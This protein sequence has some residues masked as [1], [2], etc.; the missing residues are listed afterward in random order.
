M[1]RP[2]PRLVINLP[3]AENVKIIIVI[4]TYNSEEFVNDLFASL[5][6][7]DYDLS[8]VLLVVV[9]NASKDNTL[10]KVLSRLSRVGNLNWMV[11]GLSRNYGF[12]YGNNIALHLARRVLGDLKDYTVLFL[13]PDTRILQNNFLTIVERLSSYFPL[14]GFAMLS[15]NND[16][17]DSLG[18]FVDYIGNPQDLLCGVPLTY[19]IER[20]LQSLPRIYSVTCACFAVFAVRGDVLERLG[21]LRGFYVIYFEDTEYCLRAWSMGIPVLIYRGFMVWHARLLYLIE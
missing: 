17:I 21:Y 8:R 5:I 12:V 19:A 7:Q 13:N 9:D 20:L 4:V 18:A 14:I 2:L 15:G 11:I 6:N 10:E 16:V 1:H 3:A